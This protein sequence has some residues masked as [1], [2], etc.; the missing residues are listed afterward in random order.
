MFRSIK[1]NFM[2]FQI[3]VSELG[4]TENWMNTG[5]KCQRSRKFQFTLLLMFVSLKICLKILDVFV[6]P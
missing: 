1:N 2:Q 3:Y 6:W 4:W 5:N